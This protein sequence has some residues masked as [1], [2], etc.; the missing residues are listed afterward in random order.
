MKILP[1]VFWAIVL[2]SCSAQ[3]IK[4]DL[5][6]V[7]AIPKETSKYYDVLK[8][9]SKTGKIY[10]QFETKAII[11]TTYFSSKFLKAYLNERKSYHNESQYGQ[12]AER[13]E[14]VNQKNIKFFVGFYTPNPDYTELEKISSMWQIY[15]EKPDGTKLLPL[16]VKKIN[17]PYPLLNHF[18]SEL[19]TWSTPYS[20]VF[21]KTDAEKPVLQ[22]GEGFKLVF[23]SI[24]GISSFS[25]NFD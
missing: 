8:A 7:G 14:T 12:F 10:D 21:S 24:F 5:S 19:D 13:E 20:V 15:V 9:N 3:G 1:A 18:F 2:V 16:S 25:F 4:K 22:Q 17:E 23:K 6:E 11:R